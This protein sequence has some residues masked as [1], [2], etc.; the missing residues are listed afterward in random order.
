MAKKGA[1][2]MVEVI[3][4]SHGNYASALVE[5]SQLIMGELK[6]VYPFGFSLGENVENL[7]GQVERKIVEIR[8]E[9]PDHEIM[10]LTDMKSGS[11]FNAVALLMQDYSFV[12]I[13]GVNL[14]VFLEIMGTREFQSA[15]ELK[16]MVMGIGKDTMV[17]VNKMLEDA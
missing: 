7:R 13:A 17:D 12:H 9:H 11:P 6:Q 10:I 1:E 16:E 2:K 3:V 8:E 14:P 5:S 15:Q 4:V